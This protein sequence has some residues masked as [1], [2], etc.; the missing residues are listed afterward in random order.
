MKTKNLFTLASIVLIAFLT[1]SYLPSSQ[2]NI[3]AKT[4]IY[5]TLDE[6]VQ[7]PGLVNAMYSQ[8]NDDFLMRNQAAYTQKVIYQGINVYITGS[9]HD[10]KAFFKNRARF[11]SIEQDY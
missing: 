8:L 2:A 11:W 9:F 10:W 1:F 3:T 4:S 7:N 6:A 5:I